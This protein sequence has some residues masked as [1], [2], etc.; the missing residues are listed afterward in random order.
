MLP[1]AENIGIF[2]FAN[3]LKK[4]GGPG[5]RPDTAENLGAIYPWVF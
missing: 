1:L 2:F 5:L 4:N 3:H